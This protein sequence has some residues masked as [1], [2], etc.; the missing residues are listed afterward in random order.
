MAPALVSKFLSTKK[1]LCGLEQ[2]WQNG[3]MQAITDLPVAFQDPRDSCS[4]GSV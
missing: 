3:L 1:P 2:L 4:V